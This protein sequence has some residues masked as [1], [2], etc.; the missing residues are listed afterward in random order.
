MA[1]LVIVLIASLLVVPAEF[2]EKEQRKLAQKPSLYAYASWD[3]F[4]NAFDAYV[5]DQFPGRNQVVES[6]SGMEMRSDKEIIN[7]VYVLSSDYLFAFTYPTR[8]SQ[9]HEMAET[10]AAKAKDAGLPFVYLITPQKNMMLAE[11]E[12]SLDAT[13]DTA[14]LEKLTKALDENNIPY[15]NS[16]EYFLSYPLQQRSKFYFMTDFHW[17]ELGAYTASEYF[18]QQL[19]KQ[20]YIRKTSVPDED[21]FVWINLTG[22][23][24]LGDLRRRFSLDVNVKEYIPI[25]IPSDSEEMVYYTTYNGTTA[26]RKDIV[27]SGLDDPVLDYNKMSTYNLGYMRVENPNAPEI[28]SVLL[29]KDSFACACID[30]FSEIFTELNVV[31]PRYTTDTLDDLLKARGIDLVILMYHESNVSQELIKYLK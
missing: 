9:V 18:A 17:N 25:Y 12:A 30:Y 13:A 27:G 23:D 11:G 15:V 7:D 3:D 2:N 19:A 31:D 24:Y 14:N 1:F 26:S 22:K 8:K 10:I 5:S 28:K 6:I 21:D 4:T 29:I 16:C 20:R